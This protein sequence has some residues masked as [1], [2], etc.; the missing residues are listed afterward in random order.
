VS[1]KYPA[2]LFFHALALHFV[3]ASGIDFGPS[4]PFGCQGV[5]AHTCIVFKRIRRTFGSSSANRVRSEKL[6][7]PA[8]SICLFQRLSHAGPSSNRKS[9]T[10]NSSV[11][12]A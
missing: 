8:S 6:V 3:I 7:D 11:Q 10:A 1:A 4:R 12:Q 5:L 9:E 2:C